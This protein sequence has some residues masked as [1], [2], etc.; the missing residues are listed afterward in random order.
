MKNI[1]VSGWMVAVTIFVVLFGGIYTTIGTGHWSTSRELEPIRFASGEYNPADIR[2]SYT[3]AE[4]E[5]FFGIPMDILFDAFKIPEANR[6][7]AFKIKDM[8]H[9]FAPVVID[10]SEIEVGTDLV[11]MFTSFYI[12][13]P[14]KSSETTHL[15]KSLVKVLVDEQKL[16]GERKA[17]WENHTFELVILGEGSIIDESEHESSENVA[18]KGNTTIGELIQY[19]LTEKQFK[20]IT[21][22]DM[23]SNRSVTLK[24]FVAE[25]GLNMGTIQIQIAE[26]IQP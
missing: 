3:F 9:I 16:T 7:N 20:E 6:T 24:D 11:R 25:N 2:G 4:I 13:L 1:I 17:Y 14:Y 21:G 26:T 19:G 23:P 18:I 12:G 8:E 15:P 5:R 22:V 10:G